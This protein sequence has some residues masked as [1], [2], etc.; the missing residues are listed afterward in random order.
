[1]H[2]LFLKTVKKYILV[3]SPTC[4]ALYAVAETIRRH[5]KPTTLEP[6]HKSISLSCIYFFLLPLE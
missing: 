6:I 3:A 4:L 2:K 1:M 5:P